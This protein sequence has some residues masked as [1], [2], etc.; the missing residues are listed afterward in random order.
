MEMS[1]PI[2]RFPKRGDIIADLIKRRI[3]EDKLR[4]GDK[5]P[6]EKQLTELYQVGKASIREA[7]KS[8]EVQGLIRTTTGPTGG[9]VIA[10]VTESRILNH[11][12]SYFFFKNLTAADVYEVRRTVEP[13]LASHIAESADQA[14][15]DKLARNVEASH[16]PVETREDWQRHQQV[17]IQFHELLAGHAK[18]PLLCLHCQFLNRTIRSIVRSRESPKQMALIRSNAV[19][20]EKILDAIIK[21]D[22]AAAGR[23]MYEHIGEIE[24]TYKVTEAVLKNELHLETQPPQQLS[25]IKELP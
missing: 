24:D 16:G 4:P 20:H 21:R 15:I 22:A 2:T 18:N 19:W 1:E 17:H 12:Q 8:L 10:E 11:L 9:S 14:L 23:L 13:L 7:L 6:S 5:L 3:V 25:A